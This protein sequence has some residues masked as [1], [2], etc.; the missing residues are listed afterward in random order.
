MLDEITATYQEIAREI[1]KREHLL[2]IAPE[3]EDLSPL[4]SHPSPLTSH[5]SP[6]TSHLSPLT[7]IKGYLWYVYSNQIE[8]VT[9][10]SNHL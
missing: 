4:T 8:E 1:A 7:S 5:L 3:G 9:L 6:L 10:S 2:I